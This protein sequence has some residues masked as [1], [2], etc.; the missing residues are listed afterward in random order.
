[1]TILEQMNHFSD[2]YGKQIVVNNTTWRY[3]RLGSGAPIFWLPGG[4][5]RAAFGFAFLE[6]LAAHHTVIAPDYP[7]VQTNDEYITAFDAIL[8]AEGVDTFALGGQSY[9]GGLAQVYLTHKIKFVERLI[10]SSTA[11]GNY[12]KAMLPAINVFIALARLLPEKTVKRRLASGLL[13][14]ISVPGAERAEWEEALNAIMQNDLSRADVI[15]HFA[16]AADRI[17]KDIVTPASYQNWTGRA[18]VLSSDNDPT[19]SKKYI[20]RYEQLF[21]RAVEMVNMGDLGHTAAFSNPDKYVEF[22]EQA[23]A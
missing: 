9:G 1:M 23:L 13:K 4:L 2:R 14:A 15:S 18:I 7:P 8:K 3:Y 12:S 20:P 5:R 19:Q 6:R 16:I 22:L 17:H 11:P 21:R 10:L